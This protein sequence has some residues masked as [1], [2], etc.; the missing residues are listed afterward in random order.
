MFTVC[1]LICL[2]SA[3]HFFSS[4]FPQFLSWFSRR[5][6]VASLPLHLS[7]HS[8]RELPTLTLRQN[9]CWDSVRCSLP[10]LT[11]RQHRSLDCERWSPY[12]L[13]SLPRGVTGGLIGLIPSSCFYSLPWIMAYGPLYRPSLCS[14]TLINIWVESVFF[15]DTHAIEMY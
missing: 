1:L 13:P 14:E 3:S 9:W 7:V 6:F 10:T 12:A 11:L 4:L 5:C 2:L 15:P 8:K